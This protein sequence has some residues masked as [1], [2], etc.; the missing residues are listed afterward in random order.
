MQ[1]QPQENGHANRQ[2]IA[3]SK[4]VTTLTN[5]NITQKIA[6]ISVSATGKS[7]CDPPPNRRF[8]FSLILLTAADIMMAA[9]AHH[10]RTALVADILPMQS[11]ASRYASDIRN[12]VIA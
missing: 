6:D 10:Y 4:K 3:I 11:Q 7:A 5:S 9:M 1:V 12:S 2:Y 8:A